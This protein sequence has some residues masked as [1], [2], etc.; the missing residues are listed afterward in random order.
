MVAYNSLIIKE[1]DEV[2]KKEVNGARGWGP[3]KVEKKVGLKIVLSV[4]YVNLNVLNI[5][6]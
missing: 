2:L 6:R 4:D 3:L 5:Y 1:N